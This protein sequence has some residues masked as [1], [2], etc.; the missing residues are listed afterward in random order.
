MY[1]LPLSPAILFQ[2]DE[3]EETLESYLTD[4]A[5]IESKL[6]LLKSQLL[7]IEA[8]VSKNI[9]P[10]RLVYYKLNGALVSYRRC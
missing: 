1:R 4:F 9:R 2:H 8:Q 7:G 5:S 10:I 3:V 6:D